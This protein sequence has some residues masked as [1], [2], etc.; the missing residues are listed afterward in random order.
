ARGL[1]VS[2]SLEY[3]S[4]RNV[5]LFVNG[6]AIRDRSLTHAVLRAYGE[7]MPHG[8]YPGAIAFLAGR[9]RPSHQGGGA[10]R[11]RPG[12]LGRHPLRPHPGACA[13]GM[14][15]PAPGLWRG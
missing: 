2:P 8:R 9:E 6:R 13:R 15:G 14:D 4:A 1:A 12:D 5:W 10:A 7:L 11:G 3:G